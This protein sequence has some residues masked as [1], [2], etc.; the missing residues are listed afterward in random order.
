MHDPQE[1]STTPSL[2]E[3]LDHA[4]EFVEIVMGGAPR[5]YALLLTSNR[6]R[7]LLESD[8]AFNHG[9]LYAWAE[10]LVFRTEF[11]RRFPDA[12]R[13]TCVNAFSKLFLKNDISISNL[14]SLLESD[15]S[16]EV[17]LLKRHDPSV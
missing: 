16:V 9:K 7:H 13:D 15:A 6:F 5:Q 12:S 11:L 8:N 4:Q 14:L 3:T 10:F 17:A 2:A 1:M